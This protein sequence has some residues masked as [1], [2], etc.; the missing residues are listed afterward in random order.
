MPLLTREQEGHLFRRFNYLKHKATKLRQKLDPA[1]ART[2]LMNE[3]EKLYDEAV[4]IKNEIVQANLRLVVSIAKRHVSGSEDFFGLVSDGNMSLIRAVEKFDY[5]R[6]NKFSTY[7]SW[8]IMKNFARTI[9][10]EFKRRDRFRTSQEELF[11]TKQD[12]RSDEVGQESA[13]RTREQQIE[14]ILSRLDERE[15]Q[16][17]VSRFGLDHTREPLTLKEVGSEM[18]VTKERIRQLEARALDKARLAAEEDHVEV[19]D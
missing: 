18:G 14:R 2:S 1:R 4:K 6:G 19:P 9:P 10:E 15:R 13:Q 11:T 7:A 16:I 3:I 17:I 12:V 8:A 5:S